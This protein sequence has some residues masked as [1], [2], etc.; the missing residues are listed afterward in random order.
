M[1]RI[2]LA[3]SG[4]FVAWMAHDLEELATMSHTSRTLMT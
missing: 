3:T 1:N 2:R 4:L